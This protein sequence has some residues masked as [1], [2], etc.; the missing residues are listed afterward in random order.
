MF[1]PSHWDSSV[2][3]QSSS[4]Y[5]RRIIAIENGLRY[6]QRRILKVSMG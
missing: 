6:G 3:A 5:S 4:I 1:D 2:S